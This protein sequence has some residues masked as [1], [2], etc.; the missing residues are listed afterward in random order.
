[1]RGGDNLP[2]FAIACGMFVLYI[3]L[4]YWFGLG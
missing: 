4:A 3:P 2:A 1:M